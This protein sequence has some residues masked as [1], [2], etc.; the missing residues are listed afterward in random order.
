MNLRPNYQTIIY[1]INTPTDPNNIDYDDPNGYY[2]SDT[3]HY[4]SSF[5]G[6]VFQSTSKSSSSSIKQSAIYH[7][8]VLDPDT[9]TD[10]YNS[11]YDDPDG[12]Y[13]D[14]NGHYDYAELSG[15]DVKVRVRSEKSTIGF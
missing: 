14:S 7:E 5:V 12:Y 4:D 8:Y 13:D 9:V 10:P 1:D 6:E 2:D 3:G 15:S 11:L